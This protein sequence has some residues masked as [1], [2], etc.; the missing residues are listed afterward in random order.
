MTDMKW[1]ELQISLDRMAVDAVSEI[2]YALGA[3][4]VS[5]EDPKDMEEFKEEFPYWDYIDETLEK[6]SE[7]EVKVKVYF[8]EEEVEKK[9]ILATLKR[10]V[11]ELSAYDLQVGSAE[12][13]TSYVEQ[14]DWEEGWKQYFKTF[15]A[16]DRI[17]I[18]PIWE[19]Y[20]SKQGEVVVDMDP[21]MAFGTGEHET[22][23]MCLSLIERYLKSS[24]DILDVGCGSA[25]L[26][27]AAKKLGAGKVDAI[28]LDPVAVKVARENIAYNHLSNEIRVI[29]GNLVEEVKGRYDIVVANI[30][31]DIIVLLSASVKDFLKDGGSFIA[32]G[33]IHDK[34]EEVISAFERAGLRLVDSLQKGEWNALVAKV[35]E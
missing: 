33:I 8:P 11:E 24:D 20:S 5:I 30:M 27:I 4:G 32:S 21:G 14:Q 31:A 25:I 7:E 6:P 18:R 2:L 22:T 16:T 3:K 13:T 10:K 9:N 17:V 35:E 1:M 29:E 12:I 34:R 26:S 23:A 28:D 15:H 19:E